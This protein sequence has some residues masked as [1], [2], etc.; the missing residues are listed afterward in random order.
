MQIV[1]DP[2]ILKMF[3]A[4][5]SPQGGVTPIQSQPQ[6]P[7]MQAT[8]QNEGSIWDTVKSKWD[9]DVNSMIAANAS[10]PNLSNYMRRKSLNSLEKY[11]EESSKLNM[12]ENF[13]AGMIGAVP[14]IGAG[15]INPLLG[16]AVAAG[17]GYASTLGAQ[18]EETGQFDNTKAAT[19]GA[20][21]G[22][23]DAATGRMGNAARAALPFSRPAAQTA[24]RVGV[25]AAEDI[26]SNVGSQGFEN[27]AAGRQW[28][29]GLVEAGAFGAV[30]GGALRGTLAGLNRAMGNNV[31]SAGQGAISEIND[32]QNLGYNPDNAVQ[33]NAFGYRNLKA[34]LD[35][36]IA[37]QDLTPEG[38]AAA[39]QLINQ[40]IDL[41]MNQ[42]GDAAT[43]TAL[44]MMNDANLDVIDSMY[45]VDVTPGLRRDSG[46][47]YNIGEQLGLTKEQMRQAGKAQQE[48]HA[49]KR[50]QEAIDKGLTRDADE[51]KF[52]DSFKKKVLSPAR[53]TFDTNFNYVKNLAFK[54]EQDGMPSDYI[55]KLKTV[56]HDLGTING[57]LDKYAGADKVDVSDSIRITM[58]RMK[59]LVNEL[60][61]QGDLINIQGKK[62]LW[63]P[64]ADIMTYDRIES[65][66]RARM[67]SLHRASPNKYKQG[68]GNSGE[69]FGT[70]MDIGSIAAGNFVLPLAR[71]VG[72]G[73]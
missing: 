61:L 54:A 4:E 42:G 45:D 25:N 52:Q 59:P 15:I 43:M 56:Q 12:A 60:G 69:T 73:I 29:E 35:S 39:N 44:K 7:A 3:E 40:Q 46:T 6:Q 36:K 33:G 24:A 41:S 20:A 47:T 5:T 10:D 66:G 50:S 1:T 37:S 58:Q 31:N 72:G 22:L 63:D 8:P 57:L 67:P 27:I 9:L 48:A 32:M 28:D 53:G 65:L 34:D 18:L 19:A 64:I 13:A 71:R 62:G 16:G 14:A 51:L 30:G 55:H 23:L 2:E 70:M 17:Q 26:T 49:G 68:A 21:M 38:I 11:K